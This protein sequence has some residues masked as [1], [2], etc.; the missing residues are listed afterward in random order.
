MT[1]RRPMDRPMLVRHA[2]YRWDDLRRQHQLMFPEGVLVLNETAAAVVQL[3]DGRPTGELIAA[4]EERFPGSRPA[5]DVSDFLE[6][7]ARK[8]LLRDAAD[9]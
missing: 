9:A 5:D 8:G 6:R 2:R 7:L 3:C 4:L 1:P